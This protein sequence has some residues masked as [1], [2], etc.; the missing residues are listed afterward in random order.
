MLS[1]TSARTSVSISRESGLQNTIAV[2]WNFSGQNCVE[3]RT[4]RGQNS[5]VT[6]YVVMRLN[7]RVIRKFLS[8]RHISSDILNP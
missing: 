2:A 5:F 1:K 4:V 7:I 8:V 3:I 6:M